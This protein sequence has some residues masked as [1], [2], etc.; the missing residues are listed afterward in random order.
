MTGSKSGE[1]RGGRKAGTPNKIACDF[2]EIARRFGPQ[3]IRAIQKLAKHAQS[4]QVRLAA[5]KEILDRGYGKPLATA[6]V[7]ET[8]KIEVIHRVIVD[9]DPRPVIEGEVVDVPK[10]PRRF[11]QELRPPSEAYLERHNITTQTATQE[12]DEPAL[13][14]NINDL[15]PLRN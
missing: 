4:E 13:T 1:R 3:A 10:E 11:K 2:S 9:P 8:A 15:A 12:A 14:R 7:Q 5:W 6:T